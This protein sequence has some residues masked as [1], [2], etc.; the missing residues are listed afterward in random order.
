MKAEP[1]PLSGDRGADLHWS[2]RA[3]ELARQAD[4]RTSPNPMVGAVVLDRDG[5][6]AGEGYH[7][8][9]GQPH[10]EEAALREA[11]DPARGGTVYASPEPCTHT[12][13]QPSWA[14]P[15]TE[16]GVRRPR[17]PMTD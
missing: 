2:A 16:P 1:H 17:T 10:A 8:A 6:L 15:L 9:K 7:K 14:D 4:F 5:H 13:P 11:G 12:H 3:L